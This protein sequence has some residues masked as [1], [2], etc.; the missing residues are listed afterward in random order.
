MSRSETQAQIATGRGDDARGLVGDDA[1]V[2]LGLGQRALEVEH[3]PHERVG[4]QRLRERVTR[5][6]PA[7]EVHGDRRSRVRTR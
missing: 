3:R 7:D 5:E 2:S 4:G 1:G 6:A